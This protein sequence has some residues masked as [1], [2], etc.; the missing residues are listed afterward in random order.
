[1]KGS[2]LNI[3]QMLYQSAGHHFVT[4]SC[5]Q[6]MPNG[7]SDKA[8]MFSGFL[9]EIDELW[10]YVTAGH[11]LEDIKAAISAVAEFDRWRLDDSAAKNPFNGFAI[12]YDFRIDDWMVIRDSEQGLDYA[13]LPV[14]D[15][16][17]TQLEAGGVKPLC[18]RAWGTHL[19]ANDGWAL[20]GIPSESVHFDGTT[21]LTAKVV[22]IPLQK[23]PV[24]PTAGDK[25]AN[26]FYA[27]F[28]ASPEGYIDDLDGMSGGP[29]FS[30]HKHEGMDWEYRVIGVQSAWYRMQGVLAICPFES[31]GNAIAQVVAEAQRIS[32]SQGGSEEQKS[33]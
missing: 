33:H 16:Y 21:H 29:V 10:L 27:T 30:L 12:P 26:Q 18:S 19:N 22:T 17:R 11:I 32:A 15:F 5:I 1:M 13:A 6:I 31:F 14:A 3:I 2:S 8:L 9:V 24:P 23:S 20:I 28:A 4:L 25:S 7:Q